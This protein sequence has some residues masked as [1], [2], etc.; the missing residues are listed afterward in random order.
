MSWTQRCA[1]EEGQAGFDSSL[2]LMG[3]IFLSA[4]MFVLGNSSFSHPEQG[5]QMLTQAEIAR[6]AS[7]A[8]GQMVAS[9]ALA[10]LPVVIYLLSAPWL[11]GGSNRSY[12][13]E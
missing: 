12:T 8:S 9:L 5:A 6:Q 1:S 3:V 13:R 11:F 10:A 2:I 4:L 7:Q